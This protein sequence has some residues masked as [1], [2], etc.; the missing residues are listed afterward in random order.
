M[1]IYGDKKRHLVAYPD[2]RLLANDYTAQRDSLIEDLKRIALLSGNY[3]LT[4]EARRWGTFC[5]ARLW[6]QRPTVCTWL[7]IVIPAISPVNKLTSSQA[8]HNTGGGA[9]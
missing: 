9:A 7:T 5:Y 2:D 1:F 3:L 4:S 8:C 6:S